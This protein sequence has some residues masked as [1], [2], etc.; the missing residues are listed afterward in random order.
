MSLPVV[1]TVRLPRGGVGSGVELGFLEMI[2][3]VEMLAMERMGVCRRFWIEREA[4][5]LFC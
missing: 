1:P 2:L 4:W 3:F 5:A